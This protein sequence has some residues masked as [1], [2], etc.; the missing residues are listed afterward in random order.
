MGKATRAGASVAPPESTVV[1]TTAQEPAPESEQDLE[2]AGQGAFINEDT[3]QVT[4]PGEPPPPLPDS[5]YPEGAEPLP[6][7]VEPPKRNASQPAWAEFAASQGLEGADDMS[8]D[9]LVAWWDERQET[10]GDG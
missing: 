10:P 8:R 7:A 9:E 4:Q 5:A 3:G 2:E 1:D 6:E